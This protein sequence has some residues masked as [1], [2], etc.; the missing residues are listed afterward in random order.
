MSEIPCRHKPLE[1]QAVAV[2]AGTRTLVARRCFGI[3]VN[4]IIFGMLL[5]RYGFKLC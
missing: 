2:G 5:H 4:S 1:L 3:E